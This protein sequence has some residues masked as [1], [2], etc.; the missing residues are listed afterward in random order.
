MTRVWLLGGR[1]DR[2]YVEISKTP[3]A[4]EINGEIYEA[5]TDPD[6]GKNLGAYAF[7]EER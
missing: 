5:I 4:I 1:Y 3:A 2:Q 7:N 6:T